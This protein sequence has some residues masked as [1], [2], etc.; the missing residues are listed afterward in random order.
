MITLSSKEVK[1]LRKR[2]GYKGCRNCSHQIEPLR[3]CQWLENGGDGNVH[4]ICPRWERRGEQD[5]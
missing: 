3:T 4:F 2:L 5:G 1:D